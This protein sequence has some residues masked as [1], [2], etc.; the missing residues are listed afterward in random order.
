MYIIYRDN[1]GSVQV[2]VDQYG[3]YFSEGHATFS[4]ENG[5]SYKI[6]MNNIVLIGQFENN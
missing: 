1:I 5:N 2:E 4:S 3:I 6:P